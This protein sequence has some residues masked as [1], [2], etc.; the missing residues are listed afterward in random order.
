MAS[1]KKAGRGA[2]LVTLLSNPVVRRAAIK[3]ATQAANSASNFIAAR[4]EQ[5]KAGSAPATP[6][7]GPQPIRVESQT[8]VVGPAPDEKPPPAAKPSSFADSATVESIV[9]SISSVAK[10]VA[11]KMAA[12]DAGRSVLKAINNLSGQALGSSSGPPKKAGAAVASFVGSILA[13]QASQKAQRSEDSPAR[14]APKFEPVTPP[15]PSDAPP[16]ETMQWPPR[17]NGSSSS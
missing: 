8:R 11:E 15:P 4:S 17:S 9:S 5:K 1:M 3:A 10:P 6:P 16:V 13:G 14:R 7:T 2:A 12:T